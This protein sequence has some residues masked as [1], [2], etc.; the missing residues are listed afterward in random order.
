MTQRK[1]N[2]QYIHTHIH[3]NDVPMCV[4][5]SA[6][7]RMYGPMGTMMVNMITAWRYIQRQRQLQQ[8]SDDDVGWRRRRRRQQ[9]N[10]NNVDN[11]KVRQSWYENML[12]KWNGKLGSNPTRHARACIH[13]YTVR[14]QEH[15]TVRGKT[16]NILLCYDCF[17][18]VRA[19]VWVYVCMCVWVCVNARV[20]LQ[21]GF[22]VFRKNIIM[23]EENLLISFCCT[24]VQINMK[25]MMLWS[26]PMSNPISSLSIRNQKKNK[27]IMAVALLTNSLRLSVTF[28]TENEI[29]PKNRLMG[30]DT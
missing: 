25:E 29:S 15:G 8:L 3:A 22:R 10:G 7:F 16:F 28:E 9:P 11:A 13:T 21:Y 27:K 19:C 14:H 18:S 23:P 2:F 17:S 6:S 4:W 30:S 1:L 12:R 26:P 5:L 20:N 24:A